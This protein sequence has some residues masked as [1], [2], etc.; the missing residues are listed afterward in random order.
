M[1]APLKRHRTSLEGVIFP[2]S[3]RL[4]QE[5]HDEATKLFDRLMDN[6]EPSQ[7][8]NND[9]KPI[10]LLRLTK[11]GVNA[12][13][14]FLI[15]FFSFIEH[16]RLGVT[17]TSLAETLIGLQGFQGWTSE[18]RNVL[19]RSLVNFAGYLMDNFFLPLK[20]L[21][22][23]TPQP[24]PA[25]VSRL[26]ESEQ[27]IGTPQRI[28]NLR[29]TCLARDRHR[30]VVTRKFDVRE[31]ERRY[32]SDGENVQDDDGNPLLP[33]AEDATNLEVAHIIPHSLMSHSD[34]AG[35]SKLT[36]RK[37][38]AHKILKMFN[39]GAVYLI[40][41][42]DIDREMN[43]L[44]L[45]HD[46]HQLFGNFEIAFEP[47]QGQQYTYKIDYVNTNRGFRAQKL[48]VTRT[49]YITTDRSIDPPSSQLLELHRAI[50]RILHLSAAGEYLDKFIEDMKD[51]EEGEVFSNGSTRID[52]YVR[53]KLASE[54][55]QMV[56]C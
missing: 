6:F 30:C 54:F 52:D 3:Q 23:K 35:E 25:S 21:A 50:G 24:T 1:A 2:P 49:L 44:T 5:E 33:E 34:S 27:A 53:Y 12:K 7:A 22:A 46:L 45:T 11:G 10:T 55:H 31:A 28:S 42:T 19:Y 40:S 41:G 56:V 4:A 32:K 8:S 39:P 47:V 26:K 16:E 43:A 14:E 48:P 29:K 51:I 9:Y 38:I 15:L 17:R 36:E 20:T 18:E 13:D 37:Q